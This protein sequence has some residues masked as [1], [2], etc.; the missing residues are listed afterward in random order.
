MLERKEFA[1]IKVKKNRRMGNLK[2][3][4]VVCMKEGKKEGEDK[5]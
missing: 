1:R 3:V 5:V 2:W 4:K